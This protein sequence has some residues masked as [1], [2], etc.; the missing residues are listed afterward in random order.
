[1][2]KKNETK[3]AAEAE[4]IIYE[5]MKPRQK[6]AYKHEKATMVKTARGRR[7]A[8]EDAK[9]VESGSEKITGYAVCVCQNNSTN[10]HL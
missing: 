5:V 1:M 9:K 2:H 7:K 4:G 6:A 10:E 3:K 8:L